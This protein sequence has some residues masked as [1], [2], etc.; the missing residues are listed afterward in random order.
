M[1]TRTVYWELSYL[2]DVIVWK[3]LLGP[4]VYTERERQQAILNSQNSQYKSKKGVPEG[5]K[6]TEE[7]GVHPDTNASGKDVPEE[8]G[9]TN[10]IEPN[11][12]KKGKKR[13]NK[14]K[15]RGGVDTGN[16]V[17]AALEMLKT[18]K[19]LMTEYLHLLTAVDKKGDANV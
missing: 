18:S 6:N 1:G 2:G 4:P 13:N 15:K 8:K 3:M 7:G 16:S 14:G 11:K 10:T 19:I 5:S 9:D 17:E 12:G